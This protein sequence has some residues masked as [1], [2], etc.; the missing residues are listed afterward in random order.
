[1]GMPQE[2]NTPGEVPRPRLL[3]RPSFCVESPVVEELTC[4][5]RFSFW[6]SYAPKI[7]DWWDTFCD[8][9]VPGEPMI[10]SDDLC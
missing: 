8:P 6:L 3:L 9:D 4:F 2:L 10:P 1:M 5:E 7:E